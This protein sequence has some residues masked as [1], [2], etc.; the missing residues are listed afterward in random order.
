MPSMPP[1]MATLSHLPSFFNCCKS[2]LHSYP[3]LSRTPCSLVPLPA[4]LCNSFSLRS[5]L[6]ETEAQSSSTVWYPDK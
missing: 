2:C 6:R 3:L 4:P 1:S 5:L